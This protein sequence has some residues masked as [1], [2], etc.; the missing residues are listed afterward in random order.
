MELPMNKLTR[1]LGSKWKDPLPTSCEDVED[2][3]WSSSRQVQPQWKAFRCFSPRFHRQSLLW[4]HFTVFLVTIWTQGQHIPSYTQFRDTKQPIVASSRYGYFRRFKIN[5]NVLCGQKRK[6]LGSR[7]WRLSQ[8]HLCT[9][10]ERHASSIRK[11][12]PLLLDCG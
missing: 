4:R 5:H 1:L 2:V 12:L 8:I 10:W 9:Y 3:R 6:D 11:G 7:L